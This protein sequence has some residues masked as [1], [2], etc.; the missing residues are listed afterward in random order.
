MVTDLKDIFLT[1]KTGDEIIGKI[2]LLKEFV[3][4][5]KID[6]IYCSINELSSEKHK[7]LVEFADENNIV[8]KFIP[9]SKVIFS[10]T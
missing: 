7:E 2:E 8:I 6:E 10:K 3:I 5:E 4:A 1:K 9:D